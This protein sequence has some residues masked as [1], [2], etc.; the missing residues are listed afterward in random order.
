MFLCSICS[1]QATNF[2]LSGTLVINYYYLGRTSWLGL[3]S[4]TLLVLP[5]TVNNLLLMLRANRKN[6]PVSL[7][8]A[9]RLPFSVAAWPPP[10]LEE[11][12]GFVDKPPPPTHRLPSP[13][14]RVYSFSS[15]PLCSLFSD[16]LCSPH[17]C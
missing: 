8:Q 12:G 5:R 7:F 9:R 17:S 13:V 4:Q 11:P 1:I 10:L 15:L 6:E 3:I 16:A 14:P 2:A